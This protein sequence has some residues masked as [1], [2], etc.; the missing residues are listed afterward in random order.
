MDISGPSVRLFRRPS[1]P[2]PVDRVRSSAR[3]HVA[4]FRF[5]RWLQFC[6]RTSRISGPCDPLSLPAIAMSGSSIL[7]VR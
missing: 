6:R 1:P 4:E 7:S 3:G 2:C 5:A